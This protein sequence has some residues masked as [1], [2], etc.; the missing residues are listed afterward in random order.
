[1]MMGSGTTAPKLDR[2]SL[3]KEKSAEHKTSIVRKISQIQSSEHKT[4][5][6]RKISQIQTPTNALI[7][8][9]ASTVTRKDRAISVS[10]RDPDRNSCSTLDQQKFIR[11]EN[12]YQL[13]P[14]V[15]FQTKKV[16]NIVADV[17]E[18]ELRDEKYDPVTSARS[19]LYLSDLIKEKVKLLNMKRYRIICIVII[20][21]HAQQSM[22]VASRFCWDE[23]NDNFVCS[24]Y[25]Q[26]MLHAVG[27]VFGVY[28]D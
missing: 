15:K 1:M 24:Q 23:N 14:D 20:T 3:P 6:V 22:S 11:Y 16:E 5:M 12:T 19:C 10:S 25:N 9:R 27:M 26:P 17:F 8:P 21:E 18:R 13:E 4:S 2:K 7:R 28:L